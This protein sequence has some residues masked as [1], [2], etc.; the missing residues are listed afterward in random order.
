MKP[1]TESQIQKDCVKWFREKYPTIEPLFFCCAQWWCKK[2][3]DRK[4]HEG[5]RC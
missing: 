2:C 3:L 4:D 5:R 1:Q